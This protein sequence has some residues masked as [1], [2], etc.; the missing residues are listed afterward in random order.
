MTP[1][2]RVT[3]G[4][5]ANQAVMIGLMLYGWGFDDVR[6]FFAE[7][8]RTAL[9]ALMLIG[10][11]I[12]LVRFP[13]VDFFRKGKEVVGRWQVGVLMAVF[14]VVWWVLP[15]GDRRDLWVIGDS[16]LPRY[17]GLGLVI[18]GSWLRFLGARALG[19][20]FSTYVTLQEDHQ[21]VQSG[22]YGVIRHPMYLGLLLFG[23]GLAMVFRSWLAAPVFGGLAFFVAVR[24]R[25]EEALLQQ[26]FGDEFEAYRGRTWC[27][28]PFIY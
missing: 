25:E 21:L 6:G 7:P 8:A 10:V 14:L 13:N 9:I 2:L 11:A 16:R 20:Q 4:L 27:L 5:L 1:R 17:V 24:I 22:I 26:H 28:V 19:K 3:L 15:F 18:A 23:P 12:A